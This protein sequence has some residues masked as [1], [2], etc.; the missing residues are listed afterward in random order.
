ML[1]GG[2]AS[3]WKDWLGQTAYDMLRTKGYYSV[4]MPEFNNL[5]VISVNTQAQNNLNWFLLRDPT[6][7]GGMLRWIEGEL[8]ES[9]KR[10]QFVYVIGHIPPKEA[11]N[12]WSMRFNALVDRYAYTIRGQFYGHTHRDHIGF[13]PSMMGN[14][15]HLVNSYLIAPSL[16]TYSNKHPE[17]RVMSIDLDTLQVVDYEQYR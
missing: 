6:D 17:Y 12:D 13:F 11:L 16:T 4:T 14:D 7:P 15:S 10:R 9:E 3:A 5:K 8:A 1:L 2:L